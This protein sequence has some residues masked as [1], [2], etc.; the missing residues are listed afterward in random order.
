MPRCNKAKLRSCH[1]ILCPLIFLQLAS[2]SLRCAKKAVFGPY[3]TM[4]QLHK[5]STGGTFN[6]P[7]Q[8]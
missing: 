5:Q 4:L 2:W 8:V 6:P 3:K 1:Y 7:M